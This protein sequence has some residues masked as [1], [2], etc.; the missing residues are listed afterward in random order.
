MPSVP[1]EYI[2]LV[3]PRHRSRVLY[4]NPVQTAC[5]SSVASKGSQHFLR[6]C[7]SL[8][9]SVAFT[10]ASSLSFLDLFP[11]IFLQQRFGS[12]DSAWIGGTQR[13]H[14][15]EAILCFDFFG[16]ISIFLII[17][18]R[19]SFYWNARTDRSRRAVNDAYTAR[20]CFID[21][22]GNRP[23]KVTPLVRSAC[24][25]QSTRRAGSATRW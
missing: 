23:Y 10:S 21:T 25:P 16:L 12:F 6:V 7:K 1:D 24:S 5:H 9:R 15:C 3:D 18:E 13:L 22:A 19:I 20:S 11:A 8:R 4:T 14:G 2:E 17:S